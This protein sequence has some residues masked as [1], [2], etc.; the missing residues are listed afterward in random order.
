[1]NHFGGKRHHAVIMDG[2]AKDYGSRQFD[3]LVA[4]SRSWR[5]DD[6]VGRRMGRSMIT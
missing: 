2:G 4:D 5:R 3:Q 1:M 6:H